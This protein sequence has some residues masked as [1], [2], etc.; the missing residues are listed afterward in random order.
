MWVEPAFKVFY[1]LKIRQFDLLFLFLCLWF[2]LHGIC[3]LSFVCVR[4]FPCCVISVLSPDVLRKLFGSLTWKVWFSHRTRLP[5]SFAESG[6][7]QGG[8][9][10]TGHG[11][12]VFVR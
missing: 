8:Y 6:A 5:L 3:Y 10:V 11:F 2:V 12:A 1:W 4:V 7:N 9:G